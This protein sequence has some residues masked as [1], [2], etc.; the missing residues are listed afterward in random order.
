MK[1]IP[2]WAVA[3]SLFAVTS[4]LAV[5]L[6][7]GWRAPA[8]DASAMAL[9]V[10]APPASQAPVPDLLSELNVQLE[11]DM[12][13]LQAGIDAFVPRSFSGREENPIAAASDDSL[14]WSLNVGSAALHAD[15]GA[16]GFRIPITDGR[17]SIIGRVGAKPR[18]KGPFRWL[19]KLAG[20]NISETIDFDGVVEGT[21]RPRLNADWTIDPALRAEVTLSRAQAELFGGVLRI[22]FRDAIKARIDEEVAK[23]A[24]QLK[25]RLAQDGRLVTVVER[26]WRAMHA[27]VRL[28]DDPTVWMTWQ[29]VAL[30][31]S[32]PRAAD[33]AVRMT[34]G[35]TVR[36][37]VDVTPDK[38]TVDVRALPTPT[39]PRADGQIALRIP[40]TM[41]LDRF[42][43]V[44]ADALGLPSSLELPGGQVDIGK[45]SIHGSDERLTVAVDVT[46][47][48]RWWR[49]RSARLYVSGTPVFDPAANRLAL[50]DA[51]FDV[52]TRSALI[53]VADRLLQPWVLEQIEQ[54]AVFDILETQ[55]ELLR[56]ARTELDLIETTI[57]P[58][59]DAQLEIDSG[60]VTDIVARDGWLVAVLDINGRARVRVDSIDA[61]LP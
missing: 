16:L 57:A 15:G 31:A 42:D 20:F 52:R 18:K 49:E 7:V 38:P 6:S 40:V 36:A 51:E 1:S 35:T 28:S 39:T 8:A 56:R 45:L 27:V 26:A 29:P 14:T 53:D 12:A 37:A 54:R 24:E 55:R 19:K 46:L 13:A 32:A 44:P 60:T 33:A 59:A 47:H 9:A 61:W 22:S 11:L 3:L 2:T 58:Y 43:S 10:P 23:Q 48:G 34:L 50:S 25:Q 30:A 41:Q 5:A 4:L 17:V 21:L